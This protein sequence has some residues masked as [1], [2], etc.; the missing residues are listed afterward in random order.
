MSNSCE[1]CNQSK[2]IRDPN[3]QEFVWC[4]PHETKERKNH[5]CSLFGPIDLNNWKLISYKTMENNRASY[6]Q[7]VFKFKCPNCGAYWN[8]FYH[9]DGQTAD[10]GERTCKKCGKRM[11]FNSNYLQGQ[12]LL[13]QEKSEEEKL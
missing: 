8:F 9:E 7:N 1:F 10:F 11:N 12:T 3:K 2:K 5:I 4:K 13:P 6:K